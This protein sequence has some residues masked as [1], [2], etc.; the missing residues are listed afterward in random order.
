M[1]AMTNPVNIGLDRRPANLP[2][3]V[4]HRSYSAPGG[5]VAGP[6]ED[7]APRPQFG[8]YYVSTPLQGEQR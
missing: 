5:A 6:H 2:S 8:I 4:H 7:G 3:D 1:P